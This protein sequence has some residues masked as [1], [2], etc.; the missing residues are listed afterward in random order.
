MSRF[1]SLKGKDDKN[2][3]K[4]KFKNTQNKNSKFNS[5]KGDEANN[6]SIKTKNTNATSYKNKKIV[7][8]IL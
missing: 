7:D 8:L 4:S 2:K 1:D 3:H 6:S 5:L